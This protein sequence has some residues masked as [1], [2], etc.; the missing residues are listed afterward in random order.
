MKSSL[1]NVLLLMFFVTFPTLH[2]QTCSD[3][4]LTDGVYAC[5]DEFSYGICFNLGA[6]DTNTIRSCGDGYYCNVDGSFCSPQE[7][8]TPSCETSSSTAAV[9]TCSDCSLTDGVYACMD[10]FSYGVCY[11]L[12]FVDPNAIRSCDDGFYCNVDGTF[13]SPRDTSSPSC[14]S[15][16]TPEP[17][18]VS[19]TDSSTAPSPEPSTTVSP[20][21]SST[22]QSPEPST[23]ISPPDSSTAKSP[24]PSTTVS[25]PDSS[26]A[27]SSVSTQESSSEPTSTEVPEFNA[28]AY[29]LSLNKE[30]YFRVPSDPTCKDYVNC[31]KLSGDTL[32]WLFHC[33]TDEYFNSET[34]QCETE[35]PADC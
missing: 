21:E 14:V 10:E 24:D 4:S 17:T 19:T 5:V 29:C 26:T 1:Q 27:P 31:Y 35:R 16:T 12:G 2:C 34:S 6:V 9:S 11:N 30:G 20:L 3:C 32:G 28:D 22:A 25:H 18:T 15:S 7:S 8:S 13:C 23:T 33:N